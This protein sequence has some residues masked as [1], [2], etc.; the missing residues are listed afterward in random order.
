VCRTSALR[1]FDLLPSCG[2]VSLVAF[3]DLIATVRTFAH[4]HG[5]D[6]DAIA[7]TALGGAT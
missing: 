5:Y 6:I 3:A 4:K 1:T 7:N 2:G